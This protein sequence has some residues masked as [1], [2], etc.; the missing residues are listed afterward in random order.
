MHHMKWLPISSSD[1][2]G[3]TGEK[4]MDVVI[5]RQKFEEGDATFVRTEISATCYGG[6]VF[7][8]M[9]PAENITAWSLTAE[10]GEKFAERQER[11]ARNGTFASTGALPEP[12][13]DCDCFWIQHSIGRT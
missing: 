3:K 13:R 6:S 2:K 9:L 10:H 1:P 7:R 12:R 5:H 11:L 8:L 4:P